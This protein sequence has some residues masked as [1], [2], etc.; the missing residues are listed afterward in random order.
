[1]AQTQLNRV[2]VQSIDGTGVTVNTLSIGTKALTSG[3]TIGGAGTADNKI[4]VDGGGVRINSSTTLE[5]STTIPN[6]NATTAIVSG[7]T[8]LQNTS[9][10][11]LGVRGNASI[12]NASINALTVVGQTNLANTSITNLGVTSQITLQN[13]SINGT[14]NVAGL[15]T[16]VN[17]S[18][19]S[20]SVINNVSIG[21]N[22]SIIG[23]L[24]SLKLDTGNASVNG[25]LIVAGQTVLQ[26]TSVNTTLNVDGRTT[27]RL[28]DV[29]ALATL[30]AGLNV[31]GAVTVTGNFTSSS[32]TINSETV[33]NNVSLTTLSVTGNASL[34]NVSIRGAVDINTGGTA[35]TT[36]GSGTSRTVI[37]NVSAQA[38][39]VGPLWAG[40]TTLGVTGTGALTA[41]SLSVTGNET[42]T[43]TLG[44]TGGTTLGVTGTG[45]LT[46]TG[47]TAINKSGTAITEIGSTAATS[48]TV[49]GNT[50]IIGGV[51]INTTGIGITTIGN[52]TATSRTVIGNTSMNG[53]I[54]INTT[55]TGITT[56]GSATSSTVVKGDMSVT[57]LLTTGYT[58]A[59]YNYAPTFFAA[60]FSGGNVSTSDGPEYGFTL[61][62]ATAT[63]SSISPVSFMANKK[64]IV[65]LNARTSVL[66]PKVT[67]LGSPI[68]DLT[69]TNTLYRQVVTATANTTT[70]S[71]A[72]S[73]G[74]AGNKIIWS[75]LTIEPF[76]EMTLGSNQISIGGEFNV[77]AGNPF[78]DWDPTR[79]L[80]TTSTISIGTNPRIAIGKNSATNISTFVATSDSAVNASFFSSTDGV[81][82][83][84]GNFTAVTNPRGIAY[85]ELNSTF[86]M[87]TG[88]SPA[89]VWTSTA[90]SS[91]WS[92]F[93]TTL[94][95]NSV[96]NMI[97]GN[98]NLVAFNSGTS[99]NIM[100]I[101]TGSAWSVN[102][103]NVPKTITDI[104]YGKIGGN[105]LFVACATDS[106]Y[107]NL[108][109]NP[110]GY[111]AVDWGPAT[112]SQTGTW[113]FI[114]FGNNKFIAASN[115]ATGKVS[116]SI[117]GL[118]WQ[119]PVLLN[120]ILTSEPIYLE[121]T[122][123]IGSKTGLY[124]SKDKGL[125]WT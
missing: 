78:T 61:S 116:H 25:T 104:A 43:G 41:A 42:I 50:S 52:T 54:D 81:T 88:E 63:I 67:I 22:V 71:L 55:G 92:L 77:S 65:N 46:A 57:K 105:Y 107:K 95:I 115:D 108:N 53:S 97:Y 48:R 40:A 109:T 14:L 62:A 114:G 20:L 47:A 39:T 35:T 33:L 85:N 17:V 28:L 76:Y 6:L 12:V 74:A 87:I 49:I 2:Y 99:G 24:R 69:I 9:T 66:G 121:D 98:G 68:F 30:N 117:D 90:G 1:M 80:F 19:T 32:L 31:T 83:G 8:S 123:F 37:A 106:F 23:H 64:Y 5:G 73:G 100:N 45:A 89:K 93:A 38:L 15:T 26:N 103:N 70:L 59:L 96:T 21:G 44:V 112:T 60:G 120:E 58:P 75:L 34:N 125:T 110:N 56:M 4:V 51:D 16:M 11:H 119:T 29:N 27:L 102:A 113:G 94:A 91:G 111:A 10:L 13:T 84:Q 118:N 82:W 3:I 86:Y 7:S 36:I 124:V 122:W 18:T 72:I 79:M 101:G